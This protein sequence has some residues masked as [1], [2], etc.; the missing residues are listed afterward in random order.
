MIQCERCRREWRT[1]EATYF[2]TSRQTEIMMALCPR[3]YSLI[4]SI[5][6]YYIRSTREDYELELLKK[7]L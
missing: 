5:D 4:M 1:Y 3:H 7:H 2:L 6:S